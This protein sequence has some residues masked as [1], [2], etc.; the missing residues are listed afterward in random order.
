MRI[1]V[2]SYKIKDD[3]KSYKIDKYGVWRATG[4]DI[5][6]F[7]ANIKAPNTKGTA[8]TD[9]KTTG[10]KSPKSG[11]NAP[12]NLPTT[13]EVTVNE[14][15]LL[16]GELQLVIT[17]DTL[18]PKIGDTINL[19]GF[20]SYLSGNYFVTARTREISDSGY[21]LFLTVMKKDFSR[22]LKK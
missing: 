22:S 15:F 3:E 11:N 21:A 5:K 10:T 2:P 12:A 6:P 4:E 19:R 16:E 7:V 9:T 18:K 8:K 1:H 14:K 13:K 20:G 17:S